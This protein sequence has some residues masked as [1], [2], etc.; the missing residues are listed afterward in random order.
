MQA[1]LYFV[2]NNKN[3]SFEEYFKNSIINCNVKCN[4]D[5]GALNINVHFALHS[6]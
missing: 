6:I 3:S 1:K 2:Y 5:K 4:I